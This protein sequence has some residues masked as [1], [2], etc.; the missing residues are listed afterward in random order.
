MVTLPSSSS[1]SSFGGKREGASYSCLYTPYSSL[2]CPSGLHHPSKAI[3]H[4]A[5][6]LFF[7]FTKAIRGQLAPFVEDILQAIPD[8]LTIQA[9]LPES[10]PTSGNS[11]GKGPSS[12]SGL[13]TQR[14]MSDF[15]H[16]L[17]LFETVGL[18]IAAEEG[19]EKQ[20]ILL[21]VRMELANVG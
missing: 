10:T 21:E 3:R 15:D 9:E 6:Y 12:S 4:R 14:P 2:S 17:Y 16:Q 13:P 5:W 19:A 7:R 1:F 18:L 20:S 8:L 11:A